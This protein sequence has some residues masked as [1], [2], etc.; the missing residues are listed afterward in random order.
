[1]C[2]WKVHSLSLA[3]LVLHRLLSPQQLKDQLALL[4]ICSGGAEKERD[5]YGEGD[6]IK[7]NHSPLKAWSNKWLPG[8]LVPRIS[9]GSPSK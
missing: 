9:L 6:V 5:R 1:M 3:L 8:K 7:C 4:L 2:S